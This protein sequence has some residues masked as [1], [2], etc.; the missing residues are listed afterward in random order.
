MKVTIVV[1][2]EV[3]YTHNE[4]TLFGAR[5]RIL[6][7]NWGNSVGL[8]IKQ[9]KFDDDYKKQIGIFLDFEG[10]QGYSAFFM[11]CVKNDLRVTSINGEK[12]KRKTKLNI[13]NTLHQ[14]EEILGEINPYCDEYEYPLPYIGEHTIE[15]ELRKVNK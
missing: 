14:E 15:I 2:K 11:D 7:C 8:N 1:D 6:N 10:Y 9:V 5:Q 12:L 4:F 3:G 13:K